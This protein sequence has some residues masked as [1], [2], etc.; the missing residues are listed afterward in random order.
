MTMKRRQ[1]AL[2]VLAVYGLLFSSG[3]AQSARADNVATTWVSLSLEVVR[4]TNQSTQAAGRVC[5]LTNVAMYDAVNGIERERLKSVSGPAR[6]KIRA[7]AL[8]PSD[9][10]PGLGSPRTAAAAAAAVAHTVLVAQFSATTY[11][12]LRSRLDAA[13]EAD[14]DALG[15][16]T[17]PV[18]A[19]REWGEYVGNQVLILRSN[20]G[21]QV[22]ETQCVT[23]TVP[24]CTFSFPGGP[25]Q[26]PR[27]LT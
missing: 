10:A 11:A 4:V 20:D 13:L 22:A 12:E 27:V 2:V 16:H 15:V 3:L 9:G 14:L 18:I 19:G 25:G 23:G 7:Q 24:P 5:A 6:G 8:V 1:T 17:P 26:F 21:T